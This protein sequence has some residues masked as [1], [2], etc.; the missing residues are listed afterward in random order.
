MR[1]DKIRL[2]GLQA[3]EGFLDIP[4]G[5]HRRLGE[6]QGKEAEQDRDALHI[7]PIIA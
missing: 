7:F 1:I 3:V 2:H 4:G 6:G 5:I